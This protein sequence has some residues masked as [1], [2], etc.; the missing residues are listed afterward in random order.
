MGV[1]TDDEAFELLTKLARAGD[2]NR[3]V[4]EISEINKMRAFRREDEKQQTGDLAAALI[5][6]A[7]EFSP[8]TAM[9][10]AKR[11]GCEALI[12]GKVAADA[13]KELEEMARDWVRNNPYEALRPRIRQRPNPLKPYQCPTTV[14]TC[15]L[16]VLL[17]H[18][19]FPNCQG[20]R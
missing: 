12:S 7:T 20:V 5:E 4:P 3:I 11:E 16:L 15:Q 1:L 8:V 18:P 19:P 2:P 6:I 17:A 10:V 14:L 9:R 13:A